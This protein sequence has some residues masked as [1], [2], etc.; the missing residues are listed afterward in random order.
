MLA[1]WFLRLSIGDLY[2]CLWGSSS[3]HRE[4]QLWLLE[5]LCTICAAQEKHQNNRDIYKITSIYDTQRGPL[6]TMIDRMGAEDKLRTSLCKTLNSLWSPS[7][8]SVVLFLQEPLSNFCKI[9]DQ[10]QLRILFLAST[11]RY[12]FMKI[13]FERDFLQR[14]LSSSHCANFGYQYHITIAGCF[15]K[16][17][18]FVHFILKQPLASYQQ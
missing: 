11:M 10:H 2:R 14:P 5:N 6:S 1:V 7:S 18:W 9:H 3:T 4:I 13:F 12:H 15:T 16:A 17:I 8:V